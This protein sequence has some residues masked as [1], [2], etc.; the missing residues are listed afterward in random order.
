MNIFGDLAIKGIPCQRLNKDCKAVCV[1]S[2]FSLFT[3]SVDQKQHEELLHLRQYFFNYF[4]S[5]QYI[6]KL[7]AMD[8]GTTL[9]GF[10][11]FFPF[12]GPIYSIL[13]F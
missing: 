3:I 1:F 10:S 7:K 13:I 12:F 9:P 2:F 6:D 5:Y 8:E 4:S 11:I